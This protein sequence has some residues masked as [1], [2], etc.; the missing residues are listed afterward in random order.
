MSSDLVAAAIDDLQMLR[1]TWPETVTEHKLRRDSAALRRLLV[2]GDL[3]KA[4]RLA[5]HANEPRIFTTHR[6]RDIS[7]EE[8]SKVSWAS[9]GGFEQDGIQILAPA[10]SNQRIELPFSR[11]KP[12]FLTLSR[13]VD[14][15]VAV[16]YG[17]TIKRSTLVKYVANKLGG[18]HYD[19]RRSARAEEQVFAQ[20]DRTFKVGSSGLRVQTL[21][22][23]PVY[24]EMLAVG[25]AVLR[26]PDVSGWL[27]GGGLPALKVDQSPPLGEAE[28]ARIRDYNRSSEEAAHV[29]YAILRRAALP[30][31]GFFPTSG[32]DHS[33]HHI[34]VR[35]HEV[36]PEGVQAEVV[37]ALKE[38]NLC[39]IE[40]QVD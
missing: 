24:A 21:G 30:S 6:I 32:E 19:E 39:D 37:A 5:G 8:R 25:Q 4:W 14:G 2:D 12:G 3:K 22:L 15:P 31:H 18:A 28:I 1:D 33:V 10:T 13:F 34:T 38:R 27:P 26:S 11:D 20:L 17:T 36:V 29:A 7:K 35:T 23:S 16:A 9:E 40:F